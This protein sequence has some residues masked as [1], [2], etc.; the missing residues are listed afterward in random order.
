MRNY[1]IMNYSSLFGMNSS[2]NSTNSLYG[3]L[4]QY[5]S[6]KSGAYGKLTKAYYAKNSD[7]A[8][9]SSSDNKKSDILDRIYGSGNE[10]S[11]KSLNSL[12]SESKE[13]VESAGK[14]ISTGKGGVFASEKDYNKN[15]AYEA[16]S[17]FV[18]DYN[19]TID[20]LENT[21]DS[22]V[23]NSGNSM[24]RMT[25]IMKNSLSK[26]GISIKDDGKLELSEDTFKNADFDKL[27]SV[28]SGKN[29]YAGIISNSASRISSNANSAVNRY[30][31]GGIYGS[32]GMYG[33][34]GSYN[35]YLSGMNYNS[36]F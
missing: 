1:G 34:Y 8:K 12:S 13:L 32:N 26:A 16:V 25:D 10:T 19:D 6:L 9:K 24:K 7:T 5:S 3:Q 20:K 23:R 33:G 22:T 35:S 11:M 29:S 14:L 4:S 30:G 27:K 31:S 18:S 28:F 2:N 17:K 36:F 15:T 21:N